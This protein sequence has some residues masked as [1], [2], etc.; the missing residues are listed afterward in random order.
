MQKCGHIVLPLS[1]MG[2]RRAHDPHRDR[3]IL[4]PNQALA[5]QIPQPAPTEAPFS[6]PRT[7][8]FEACR[9]DCG[10]RRA[11][12]RQE[13]RPGGPR[14]QGPRPRRRTCILQDVWL[15]CSVSASSA[16][17]CR[18]FLERCSGFGAVATFCVL[19]RPRPGAGHRQGH[20]GA[21]A[22]LPALSGVASPSPPFLRS[23]WFLCGFCAVSARQKDGTRRGTVSTVEADS[24]ESEAHFYPRV[25]NGVWLCVW[26]MQS[27]CVLVCVR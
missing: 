21:V 19:G 9:H 5:T 25:L 13:G 8:V 18:P 20:V 7:H 12:R 17:C 23:V 15:L 16:P 14:R 27:R 4:P 11:A 2:A 10:P 26:C 6:P 3:P 1:E 22:A 24:F